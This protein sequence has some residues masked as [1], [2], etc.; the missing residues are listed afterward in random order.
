MPIYVQANNQRKIKWD[1]SKLVGLE[2]SVKFLL[3]VRY[4]EEERIPRS[5]APNSRWPRRKDLVSLRLVLELLVTDS[6]Q[7][8]NGVFK[9]PLA[10][11]IPVQNVT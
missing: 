4:R 8:W 1:L 11:S 6:V 9:R 5:A 3:A 2:R 10:R 7:I